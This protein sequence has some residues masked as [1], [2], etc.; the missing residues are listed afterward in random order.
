MKT[1]QVW[2]DGGCKPNPGPGGWAAILRY[3][4]VEKELSGGELDTT[5]NRM[6]LTA[7]IRALEAVKEPCNVILYT[8]SR[9]VLNGITKWV[10]GW[11]RYGWT[12]SKREPVINKD[13]WERLYELIQIHRVDWCWVKGHGSSPENNR[14]DRLATKAREDHWDGTTEQAGD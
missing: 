1:I 5:N 2:T 14:V 8:D 12:T 10:H 13:L 9:Y 7:A 6:E 3:K 4:G 11:K